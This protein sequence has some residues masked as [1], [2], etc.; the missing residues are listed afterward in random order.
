MK[1]T[2]C[3]LAFA[4]VMILFAAPVLAEPVSIT[5]TPDE[6]KSDV[7][8]NNIYSVTIT[9][10]QNQRDAFQFKVDGPYFWWV[11]PIM[12]VELDAGASRTFNL[13]IFP[14]G[15]RFGRFYYTLNTFS[16]Y[17]PAVS[18]STGFYLDVEPVRIGELEVK[19]SGSTLYITVPVDSLKRR[20]ILFS[21]SVRESG[22]SVVASSSFSSQVE[23]SQNISGAID[24][25]SNLLA[26]NYT[27]YVE[28]TTSGTTIKKTQPFVLEPIH[29][30]VQTRAE[31]DTT[32]YKEITITVKNLGNIVEDNYMV[33]ETTGA[34]QL[35]GFVTAPNECARS[36]DGQSC[37]YVIS[38]LA[39][40]ATAQVV[41]RIEFWPTLMQYFGATVVVLAVL[42]FTFVHKTRPGIRKRSVAHGEGKHSIILE[43][44]NPFLHHLNNVVVRDF[45][46]PVANV[47]HEEIESLK[48]VVRKTEAGTE[49]IWKLGDMKPKETRFL[50]YGVR[51]VF[52]GTTISSPKAYI[53]FMNPK[54]K[55][56]RIYSN[57]LG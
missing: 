56:F 12:L 18:D 13:T 26:G 31:T 20:D 11:S 35:T 32:L 27:L 51:S 14:T 24:L 47:L 10:N 36:G 42:G 30:V 52:H 16:F 15:D 48:P 25:P 21:F 2:A 17:N 1:M 3:A 7:D 54:G 41:Y 55:S 39:P 38:G 28:A 9:N 23:G 50:K 34:N 4:A 53:R 19:K 29:N 37:S 40:G 43:I 5:V 49:L 6:I 22:G 46:H 57:S 8:V 33:T 44:R 45:V